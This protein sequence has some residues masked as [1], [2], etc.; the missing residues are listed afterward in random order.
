MSLRHGASA[1]LLCA[2]WLVAHV[3]AVAQPAAPDLLHFYPVA[4]ARAA[5]GGDERQLRV[6]CAQQLGG[7]TAGEPI[8]A[9]VSFLATTPGRVEIAALTPAPIRDTATIVALKPRF[10]PLPTARINASSTLDWAY[11]F[12]RNGDGRIDYVAVLDNALPVLP[13]PLPADFPEVQVQ[14]NGN[15]KLTKE[16]AY[17]MI[18]NAQLVFRHYADENFDGRV[19][20]VVVDAFDAKRPLFIADYVAY[21]RVPGGGEEAW[22]FRSSIS[23]RT[24]A[25]APVDGAVLLPSWQGTEPAA[26]RVAAADSL[27]QIFNGALARCPAATP[28]VASGQ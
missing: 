26:A 15:M 24:A 20:A 6:L 9:W 23:E 16:L 22:R 14:P 4:S 12:D 25:V 2:A 27:L 13:D 21:R 7:A 1:S 19:E 5:A 10:A 3:T 18:D 11:V 17:A 8:A 28:P